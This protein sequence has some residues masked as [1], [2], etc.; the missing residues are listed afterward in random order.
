MTYRHRKPLRRRTPLRRTGWPKTWTRRPGAI[1][2]YNAV[3][4]APKEK[5]TWKG[6][7]YDSK[8]EMDYG[9]ILEDRQ[10]QGEIT[11]IER[12]VKFELRVNG[13]LITN[14]YVDFRI[15]LA[16]GSVELIEVKGLWTDIYRF[17]ARLL[18][19]TYL[20][21]HPEVTYRVIGQ[22]FQEIPR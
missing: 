8:L 16:D 17:K 21:E 12:Q 1:H 11:K 3:P 14:H 19:A 7:V 10:K 5:R 20:K 13:E 9:L 2:R 22:H 15:T 18:R 4:V 6:V